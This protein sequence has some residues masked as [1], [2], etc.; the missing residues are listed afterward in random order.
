MYLWYFNSVFSGNESKLGWTLFLYFQTVLI[1][2]SHTLSTALKWTCLL[3][4][5]VLI[6]DDDNDDDGDEDVN[7]KFFVTFMHGI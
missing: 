5:K 2:V 7:N 4:N 1:K 6:V 3:C